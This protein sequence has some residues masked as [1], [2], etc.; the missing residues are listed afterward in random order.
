MHLYRSQQGSS[1]ASVFWG[2]MPGFAQQFSQDPYMPANATSN[3]L[4]GISFSFLHQLQISWNTCSVKLFCEVIYQWQ[5]RSLNKTLLWVSSTLYIYLSDLF[6]ATDFRI[7]VPLFSRP[8]YTTVSLTSLPVHQPE[9]SVAFT[10]S[11]TYIHSY[12][13]QCGKPAALVCQVKEKKRNT[14]AVSQGLGQHHMWVTLIL[15][16]TRPPGE[17]PVPGTWVARPSQHLYG[18]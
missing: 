10:L 6:H 18:H 3:F 14:P 7:A 9:C 1:Q 16:S 13:M 11:P 8:R 12:K 5:R 15:L 2:W 4:T 17:R